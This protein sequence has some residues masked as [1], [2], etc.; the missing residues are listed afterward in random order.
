MTST[1]L[2]LF[3]WAAAGCSDPAGL[4][5][6]SLGLVTAAHPSAH[7]AT[8]TTTSFTGYNDVDLALS[9]LDGEM[10][11]WEGSFDI[12]IAVVTMPSG[13]TQEQISIRFAP[14]HFVERAN[15]ARYYPV[16][17]VL[18]N[19][20]H[21]FGPVTVI[22]GAVTGAWRSAD[23]DV[24]TLGFHVSFVY[25]KDGNLVLEKWNGACP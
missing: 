25:D 22:A 12:T 11:H 23:G 15:G 24:L 7:G 20:H 4:A 18:I 5:A 1:A 8:R 3:G 21:A 14:D 16:G 2:F 9:C 6:G 10:T 19:E 17:Q 13:T